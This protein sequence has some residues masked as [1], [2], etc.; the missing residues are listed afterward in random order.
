LV[1]RVGHSEAE[2]N[3]LAEIGKLL[4][5]EFAETTCSVRSPSAGSVGGSRRVLLE[6]HRC[7]P[8]IGPFRSNEVIKLVEAVT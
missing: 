2:T 6:H 8:A 1:R 5:E 3:V 4:W 7:G